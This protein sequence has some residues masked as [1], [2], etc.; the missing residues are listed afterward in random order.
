MRL[1]VT[2]FLFIFYL[3]NP[4]P[5]AH[6]NIVFCEIFENPKPAK[7]YHIKRATMIKPSD[8][9]NHVI[10]PT[11]ENMAEFDSRMNTEDAVN[12]LMGIAAVESKLGYH[13]MQQPSGP[14]RGIYQMEP[15]THSDVRRYW[16]R[17]DKKQ[18]GDICR[19]MAS[20]HL[21][22]DDPDLELFTNLKYQT[23]AAR[24]RL[25]YVRDA[26]PAFDDIE[27]QAK[28]WKAHYNT[29]GGRGTEDHYI[30]SHAHYL[31]GA[32]F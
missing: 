23:C 7:T 11:L 29:S 20:Q 24:V 1:T 21:Y 8:L 9:A 14:A 28:Y 3:I 6:E 27:G 32:D 5:I 31:K 16:N 26:L 2:M 17:S 10:R 13:L 12:L 4:L 30:A 25:W 15:I 19:G 18:L 22:D